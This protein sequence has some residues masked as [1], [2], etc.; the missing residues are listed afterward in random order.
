M[1]A[2]EDNLVESLNLINITKCDIFTP[3]AIAK[4]MS[5]KL[6]EYY[7]TTDRKLNILE[8]SVGNG[9]LLKYLPKNSTIDVYDIKRVY[10]DKIED[11]DN[12]N[13]HELNH[14]QN[15]TK[16]LRILHILRY[17]TYPKNIE[18]F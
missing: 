14:N 16:L 12:I 10:L 9:A 8:P 4:Q 5:D 7:G 15:M 6:N 11:A 17:K 2:A 1:A 3:D 18:T 13:K